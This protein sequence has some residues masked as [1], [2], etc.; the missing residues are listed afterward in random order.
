M[1]VVHKDNKCAGSVKKLHHS[2]ASRRAQRM[3]EQAVRQK[4]RFG[5]VLHDTIFDKVPRP[6]TAGSGP[7]AE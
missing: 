5:G 4:T 6:P 2:F 3:N 1:S 7:G